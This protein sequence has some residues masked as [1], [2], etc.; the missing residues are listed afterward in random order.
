MVADVY[1]KVLVFDSIGASLRRSFD[2]P[3][4]P[5][6]GLLQLTDST[7]LASGPI[8]GRPAKSALLHVW[9]PYTNTLTRSFLTP[10]YPKDFV[11]DA[12]VVGWTN[13]AVR[14]GIIAAVVAQ[15]DTVFLFQTDGTPI[16][17]VP[18]ASTHFRRLSTHLAEGGREELLQWIEGFSLIGGVYWAPDGTLLVQ[19]SDRTGGTSIPSLM[20]IKTSGQVV[21]ERTNTPPLLAVAD[22]GTLYFEKP[23]SLAPNLWAIA[24]LVE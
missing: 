14:N 23:N 12:I 2:A 13:V 6:N 24:R 17:K 10:G 3:V 21:F 18:L 4:V 20:R 15:L 16:K 11:N 19:Y 22:D 5:L 7:F 8:A 1:G 9:N